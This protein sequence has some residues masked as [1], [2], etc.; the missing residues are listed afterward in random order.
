MQPWMRSTLL[1][2]GTILIISTPTISIK[3]KALG[4]VKECLGLNPCKIRGL[5]KR[6]DNPLFKK[7]CFSIWPRMIREWSRWS[8][9]WPI[10]NLSCHKGNRTTFLHSLSQILRRRMSM[11]WWLEARGFKRTLRRRKVLLQKLQMTSL[12]KRTKHL[13]KLRILLMGTQYQ[14]RKGKKKEEI[15]TSPKVSIHFPQRVKND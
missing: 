14:R 10:Y 12:L 13:R 5:D 6:S 4:K 3:D 7:P 1:W 15:L 11:M 9:N 8:P 2:E